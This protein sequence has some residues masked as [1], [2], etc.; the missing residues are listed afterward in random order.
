MPLIHSLNAIIPIYAPSA[1]EASA[2]LPL[3]TLTTSEYDPWYQA[4]PVHWQN[5]LR[6][7]D[8]KAE[9]GQMALLP[10][11]DGTLAMVV[12]LIDHAQDP[13]GLAAAAQN[14]PAGCYRLT[15]SLTPD[16]ATQLALG[17]ALANY[18]FRRYRTDDKARPPRQLVVPDDIDVSLVHDMA[19]AIWMVRDLVNM[20]AEDLGPHEL[21]AAT[22]ALALHIGGTCHEI[23]GDDLL[24]QNYPAIH[25]VGR[26]SP[27]APRLIEWRW[28]EPDHPLVTLVGKGVCFDTGGLDI[29]PSSS[30]LNMKKD[31]GGAAHAL[32]LGWLIARRNLPIRLRVL[33]P[34]VDNAIA[35]NAFRPRDVLKTRKGLTVEVGNTDAEGRLILADALTE[36]DLENPEIL[37]DF[38]TLTGAARVALGPSLPAF[39]AQDDD[40]A[41][42]LLAAA[43]AVGDPFWR[44]P[45]WTEYAKGLSSSIADTN[46]VTHDG[47]A[48]SITAALFLQKFVRPHTKWG[49]FDLFAWNPSNRP[50]RPEGGEAQTL[51]ACFHALVMLYGTGHEP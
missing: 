38:A 37:L 27:R 31:M 36:A 4:Q 48:G 22:R 49:H 40:L 33:V 26:A 18:Q 10:N 39:Y 46:S 9:A 17:W 16:E 43:D 44:M 7:H 42:D 14:L 30:M 1:P 2:A 35:G 13:W 29:K 50:G 45:L 8:F 47:F 25:A 32:A 28:G 5:W 23:I 12:V 41:L 24:A 3:Q 51:R 34:A 15:S 11:P 19:R 6:V 20:P 21:G